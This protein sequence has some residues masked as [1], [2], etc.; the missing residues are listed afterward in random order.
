MAETIKAAPA[1][2]P[3]QV[4]MVAV[5][6]IVTSK[7]VIAPGGKFFTDPGNAT[8]LTEAGAATPVDPA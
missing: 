3:K 6:E 8:W 4:E 5:H 2:T 7:A 1:A